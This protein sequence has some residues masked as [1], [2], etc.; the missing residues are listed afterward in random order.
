MSMDVNSRLRNTKVVFLRPRPGWQ[1]VNIRELW[2]N[3]ELIWFLGWRDVKVR[4]KQTFLGAAW[5]LLQPVI[6]M[7]V[8]VAFFGRLAGFSKYSAIPYWQL[9]L[10]GLLPWQLF[11]ASIAGAA[12]SVI[13]NSALITKVYF[14]RMA[15]P[16]ASLLAPAVDFVIALCLYGIVAVLFGVLPSR[17]VVTV[18]LFVLLVAASSTGSGL[19]LAA[20]NVEYR[21]VR[22]I[23]PF[24][25][26]IWMYITPIVYPLSLIPLRWR[27]LYGLNPMVGAVEGFRWAL[28]SGVA[29]PGSVIAGSAL[30]AALLCVTGAFY[31]RRAERN[32]ADAI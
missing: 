30:G 5:A 24:L 15:I 23:V 11:S 6:S 25:V 27:F 29:W 31:F 10:C 9:T 2:V 21:D 19:W 3:R 32:F 1:P 12:G 18:P 17:W 16:I 28:I 20:L 14:P 4:Y 22:Y 7:A 8:F 13:G 26:Q